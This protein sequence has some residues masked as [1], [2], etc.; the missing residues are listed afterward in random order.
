MLARI[1]ALHRIGEDNSSA[2]WAH[3]AV[4]ALLFMIEL[5]PVLVK[6]LTSIGPPSLYDRISKLDD[7]ST[8]DEATRHRA[9]DRRR[10]ERE[11]KKQREIDED[12]QEREKRLGVRGNAHVE[13]EME[14][15]LDAA[16]A[17]W[18]S[19]VQSH[20]QHQQ[21]PPAQP[22][23]GAGHPTN[24]AGHPGQVPPQPARPGGTSRTSYNLPPTGKL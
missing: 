8:I 18:S 22:V 20:L 11:S 7:D 13:K 23:N 19:Q 17:R 15:I 3:Y 21:G 12:M 24:G 5:L 16:L 10:I 2:K 4:A 1:E 6:L 9:E 14:K